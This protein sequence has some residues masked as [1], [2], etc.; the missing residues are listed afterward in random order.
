MRKSDNLK[1]QRLRGDRIKK[2]KK[3]IGTVTFVDMK[4]ESDFGKK[5]FKKIGLIK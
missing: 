3:F 4:L 2:V 1:R 5:A